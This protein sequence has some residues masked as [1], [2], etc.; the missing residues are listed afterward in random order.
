MPA[1]YGTPTSRRGKPAHGNHQLHI[2]M[3]HVITVAN[4]NYFGN[5]QKQIK[6]I[7]LLG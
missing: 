1:H 3:L 2:Q 5:I 7:K 6:S 4:S